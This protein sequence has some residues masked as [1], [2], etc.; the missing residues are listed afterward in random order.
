MIG[1]Y[2]AES[3][4][5]MSYTHLSRHLNSSELMGEEGGEAVLFNF[6]IT[7]IFKL[8]LLDKISNI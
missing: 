2:I 6:F 8:D 7:F 5:K 1:R 4:S 3:D